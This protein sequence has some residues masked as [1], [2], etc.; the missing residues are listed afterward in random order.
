MS[1]LFAGC[2]LSALGYRHRTGLMLRLKLLNLNPFHPEACDLVG[3]SKYHES[4]SNKP[5]IDHYIPYIPIDLPR[6]LVDFVDSVR[7]QKRLRLRRSNSAEHLELLSVG[8]AAQTEAH[9]AKRLQ[10]ALHG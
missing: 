2:W 6:F 7:P 10:M 3:R 1:P 9:P 8:A 5:L 4:I